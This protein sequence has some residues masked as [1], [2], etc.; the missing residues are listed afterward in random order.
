MA[1]ALPSCW[2]LSF[3]DQHYIQCSNSGVC[4]KDALAPPLHPLKP[5]KN[6]TAALRQRPALEAL[7]KENTGGLDYLRK[8]EK[9]GRDREKKPR[10]KASCKKVDIVK[11]SVMLTSFVLAPKVC[12][13]Y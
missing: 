13:L 6:Q 10:R 5:R 8:Q 4:L 9:R 7:P 2:R 12:L 3:W 1:A 11:L